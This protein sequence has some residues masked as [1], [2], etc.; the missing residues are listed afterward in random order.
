MTSHLSFSS[1][2]L[3]LAAA[4]AAA[5]GLAAPLGAAAAVEP[6]PA[7]TARPAPSTRPVDQ[8]SEASRVPRQGEPGADNP[9]LV[10]SLAGEPALVVGGRATD[11]IVL[12]QE[13]TPVAP[14]LTH[15]AV[16]ILDA[17]GWLRADVLVADL[18]GGT[19]R[20]EYVNSGRVAGTVPLQG[21]VEAEPR[22]VAGVNGDFFD[23]NNS[24]AAQGVGIDDGTLV[25]SPVAG[26]DDA[27]VLDQDG[28]GAL[29]EVLLVGTV[30][31]PG[32]DDADVELPLA[33]A[34]THVLP[35]NR[36]GLFTPAWG[37]YD[38]TRAVSGYA[39]ATAVTV[40]AG[41]VLSVG[42]PAE[43]P[44][45]GSDVELV[46]SG[47]AG[48]VLRT[49]QPGDR[50]DVGYEL[51]ADVVSGPDGGDGQPD[52]APSTDDP[53]GTIDVAIGGSQRLVENGVLPPL[54]DSVAAP[55]TSVGFSADGRTMYLATVDGRQVDSR[56]M[57]LAELGRFMRGVGADDAL[58]LDGGGSSTLLARQPGLTGVE[59]ENSPSDGVERAVPNGLALTA[60]AGSGA[61]TGIA[62]DT[63]ETDEEAPRVFP[64]L[65]RTLTARPHDETFAPAGTLSVR[66][67]AAPAGDARV[68]AAG[69]RARDAAVV[70]T[71]ADAE[72]GDLTVS[73]GS[74]RTTSTLE[75]QVLGDLQRLGVP[76]PRVG[77]AGDGASATLQVTGFDADGFSAPVELRDLEVTGGDG[78]VA[79]TADEG[80]PADLRLTSLV[81]S[82]ST[83][84]EL[85]ADGVTV[86]V[87]VTVGLEQRVV[88]DFSDAAKWRWGGA[89]STGTVTPAAGREDD[90]GLR[91]DYDFTASTGTR[92]ANATPPQPI[93][94]P[95]QPQ[96]IGLWV[97]GQ[98]KGEWTAFSTVDGNGQSVPIYGPYITWTGWRYV[99]VAVPD[100]VAY[101]LTFTR[102]G[103][104]ETVAS[105]Q[106]T[107]SL[108]YDDLTVTVPPEVQ[109]PQAPR[110]EDPV[111]VTEAADGDP[112]DGPDG[113]TG[114]TG[115]DGRPERI[116]VMSDAQFIA[117]NPDSDLVA[118]AL[119]TMTEI[120]AAQPDHVVILGDLVD[121]SYPEDFA[122]ARRVITE[123]LGDDVPWTYVPGNHEVLGSGTIDNFVA[124]FGDPWT[125][126]DVGGTRVVTLSSAFG[127]L[128]GA[129]FQQIELLR[130]TLDEAATDDSVDGVVV[131]AH[132]PVVDPNPAAASQLADRKEAEL[133]EDWLAEFRADSGKGAAYVSAH[134][135]TFDASSVD[136]VPFLVNG[137]SA[138]GPA[139]APADGGFV[140]WTMLGMDPSQRAGEW[141]RAQT[142][143]WVERLVVGVAT[144][145]V[146]GGSAPLD[147]VVVQGGREVP[148]AWPVS[149]DVSGEGLH[150]GDVK[151]AG[152]GAVAAYDPRTG[153]VTAL[154]P[155]SAQVSVTVNGVTETVEVT[156]TR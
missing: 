51:R 123:G 94:L 20:T 57:T 47:T 50:V 9:G 127:T 38:R 122:L 117:A 66:W 141:L 135:G 52:N 31:V 89:R 26:H 40:R 134:A 136:D 2:R 78:V 22:A 34:N 44:I 48:Q 15:T 73:A 16:D 33:G 133:V 72:P 98:G 64:G 36:V 120:V 10:S 153:Q 3:G 23:I 37:T 79:V 106:Y 115:V 129:G 45:A 93:V 17:R 109:V 154:R 119:R 32:P 14:G 124:E 146:V 41:Q 110:V 63:A 74:G 99:E 85:T 132:H 6:G 30:T 103:A 152:A 83:V 128:R 90:T 43:G 7:E 35:A 28:L 143:P 81:A 107:G 87:A 148:V 137:N 61:V 100:G 86:S 95:G 88:A 91:I 126:F 49:L 46:G 140:G 70:L 112:G 102:F 125:T 4:V 13:T 42:N 97:E 62:L 53:V 24:G 12:D 84:L 39:D 96:S 151:D 105:K 101:P 80:A 139:S 150:V 69:P 142:R 104:I 60:V 21:P 149:Y 8:L 55:R 111:V 145:M 92:T 116:A 68:R 67:R 56:G 58:N 147:A 121:T 1:T 156:I 59:V 54:D 155:G 27:L 11:G 18:D 82:G 138:K 25:Q 77:L 75:L 144:T 71:D 131:M 130:R 65:S 19:L 118:G 113:S 5:V 114:P 108:R 29:A 76:Q